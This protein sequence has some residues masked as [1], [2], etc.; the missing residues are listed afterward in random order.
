MNYDLWRLKKFYL[1]WLGEWDSIYAFHKWTLRV[2]VV[3]LSYAMKIVLNNV[4]YIQ[5]VTWLYYFFDLYMFH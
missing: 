3:R 1:V 2:F 4:V 5:Y